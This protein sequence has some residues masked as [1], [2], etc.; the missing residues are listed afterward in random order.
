MFF[1][2]T[3]KGVDNKMVSEA[4]RKVSDSIPQIEKYSTIINIK[5]ILFLIK[6]LMEFRYGKEA[7]EGFFLSRKHLAEKRNDDFSP[8]EQMI[9]LMSLAKMISVYGATG[10]G[11]GIKEYFYFL[12][13]FNSK[14]T[15]ADIK[16]G[17]YIQYPRSFMNEPLILSEENVAQVFAVETAYIDFSAYDFKQV[18]LIVKD[19]NDLK[20][21][22]DCVDI[23]NNWL[24]VKN[25]K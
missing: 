3:I 19:H 9:Q 25:I 24:Q 18:L 23:G 4:L 16:E 15:L 8:E 11:L 12:R 2:K 10:E 1:R 13:L 7:S 17:D 6:E 14:R 5:Y 22:I 20:K 21:S